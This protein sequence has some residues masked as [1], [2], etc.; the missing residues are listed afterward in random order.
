MVR[1]KMLLTGPAAAMRSLIEDLDAL[2]VLV[3]VCVC[4]CSQVRMQAYCNTLVIV[5]Y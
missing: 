4:E 2:K 1:N 3:R 5:R